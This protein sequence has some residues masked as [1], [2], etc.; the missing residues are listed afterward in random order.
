[1]ASGSSRAPFF[2]TGAADG[3]MVDG[4][5]CNYGRGPKDR[6][7]EARAAPENPADTRTSP[8]KGGLSRSASGKCAERRRDVPC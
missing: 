7:P 4:G 6:E 5:R 1:M 8:E 3:P 2:C